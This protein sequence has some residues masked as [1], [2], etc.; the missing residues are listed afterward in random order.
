MKP[1]ILSFILF[2]IFANT[3]CSE[4]LSSS[5]NPPPVDKR[6]AVLCQ[7]SIAITQKTIGEVCFN[8]RDKNYLASLQWAISEMDAFI[9]R[10]SKT[11]QAQLDERKMKVE[12]EIRGNIEIDGSGE[13]NPGQASLVFYPQQPAIPGRA[14]IE[15]W[16]KDLLAVPRPPVMNPCL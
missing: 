11:T 12:S 5:T 13:C 9:L 14:A 15:R 6:G 3:A 8:K 16:I 1:L 4:D 7:W 10:N 2:G